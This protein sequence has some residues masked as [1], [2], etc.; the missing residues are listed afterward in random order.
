MLFYTWNHYYNRQ[1]KIFA[2]YFKF[3]GLHQENVHLISD[4][5]TF[6]ALS[7]NFT[8][9]CKAKKVTSPAKNSGSRPRLYGKWDLALLL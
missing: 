7:R 3:K 1:Q 8:H 4:L 9:K 6:L 2:V 5:L